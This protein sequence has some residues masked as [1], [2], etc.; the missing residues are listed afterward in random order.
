MNRRAFLASFAAAQAARAQLAAPD[1]VIERPASG[2]PH[3]GK[4]LAAIQPHAD[5]IPIFAGGTVAKLIDEGYTGYLIHVPTTTWPGPAP[6]PKPPSPTSATWTR[7][8]GHG[9]Q[10][11][12]STSTT[13]TTRWTASRAPNSAPA[14]SFSSAC[15]RWIR[16]SATILGPLRGEPRPLR[17]RP[18]ASRRPAGWPAWTRTTP[19]TSPP[20]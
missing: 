4:V 3:A 15:S 5:D 11:A 19:S 6:S 10:A 7:C 12:S 20:A 2:K 17:H 8:T 1:V 9:L 18:G 16:W 14:S 13:A